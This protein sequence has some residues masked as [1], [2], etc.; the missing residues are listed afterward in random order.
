MQKIIVPAS[1]CIPGMI[2]AG[3]IIDLK[4][5]TTIVATNQELTPSHIKSILNFV[6]TDIWVYLDSSDKVWGLSEET[7]ESYKKYSDALISIVKGLD[8]INVNAIKDFEGLCSSLPLDFSA[9]HSLVG[10]T[11]LIQELDYN[12]YNHSLNVAFIS[13]LICRWCN[14]DDEFT[15]HAIKAGLLHDIGL[16]NLSFNPFETKEPWSPEQISEYEKHPIYSY[17]IVNK[18]SDL[19]PMISKAILAH[20][21]HCDG[22]GFPIRISAPYIN[23]LGK[24]LALAD[25]FDTLR[26]KAHIFSV[27]K[28]LLV[29]HIT[30]FDPKLLLTFCTY[31]A[32]YYVGS[33]VILN[34]G[35]IGEVV[36]INPTCVY[37]PIVKIND[38]FINLYED[39]SIEIVALK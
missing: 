11:N 38:T 22:T 31:I 33:F 6:H 25:R 12:T 5:G 9:N 36:F 29:D 19:D 32:T 35:L 3:P 2:T 37:R 26:S 20:H 39:S 14:F 10:C 8:S 17:N 21:E 7:I 4:T 16:I 1:K 13:L 28:M 30:E 24:V 23:Q 18:L 15:T 34:N 27:L